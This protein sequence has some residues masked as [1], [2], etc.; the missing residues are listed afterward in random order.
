MASQNLQK[1]SAA[2]KTAQAT[3]WLKPM[4]TGLGLLLL[5]AG[6][7]LLRSGIGATHLETSQ[8]DFHT[9]GLNYSWNLYF[10][11][12]KAHR[13]FITGMVLL[14][15]A[16]GMIGLAWGLFDPTPPKAAMKRGLFYGIGAAL[17]AFIGFFILH[18]GMHQIGGYDQSNL[19][20]SSWRLFKGQTAYVD[21]PYTMPV[22][23]FLGGKFAFQ[24][25]GVYYRSFV[26]MIALFAIP[27]FA[28]SLFL[29]AQL[30]GRSWT[31]LLWAMA[32]QVFSQMMA[33]YWTY[34]PITAVAAVL[35][36]FSATYWLRRP[37]QK[38]ALASYGAALLL[39]A[40]MKPNVAGILIPG[41]SVIL[42]ISPN[43]R[44]KVLWV[45]LAAFALFLVFLAINHLSFSGM[46]AG[47]LSVAQRGASLEPF[48]ID[49]NPLEKRTAMV[50]LISILLPAVLALSQGRGTSRSLVS[51]IPAVAMLAG[52]WI[53][54]ANNENKPVGEATIFVPV[55]LALLLGFR[56]LRSLGPWIPTFALLGGLYGYITN[57]EQKLVDMPPVLCAALLLVGELRCSVF[58]AE[59]PVFQMPLWWN[60]YL[61]LACVVLVAA[62]L[63]QGV[64]RD[65]IQ[66]IGPVQFFEWDDS[67]HIIADGLF[68][69]VHCGDVLDEVVKE[70]TEVLRREPSSTV[71][72]G[73]R[74]Q[75]GYANFNVQS[76]LHEPV[77]W[78]GGRTMYAKS[79]EDYY[80]NNFL[81]SRRQLVILFKNDVTFLSQDE[82]QRM[83]QQYNVDQSFPVL[84][85]LHLK[86]G[87]P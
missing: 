27:T 82:V 30:F 21:F 6:L 10:T 42:F 55:A 51:W 1:P 29:L 72:F 83:A 58:P 2:S 19:V 22:A 54:A 74:M 78:D 75:W 4:G 5:L 66:S 76:P 52:F 35:Y 64:A 7:S 40:T 43:H 77:V 31:T 48:L 41:I 14:G 39:L 33:A 26:D 32:M 16:A 44:W 28:W 9:Q 61:A 57:S 8:V 18:Y 70:T 81:Q 69:G 87:L 25:F 11:G 15:G 62:G 23:Y 49:L 12:A 63:A 37:A 50:I 86:K 79:K 85:I 60:R 68:K 73:P 46:L 59:G 84:T 67:R 38:S 3:D 65:R 71:W 45:S 53:F 34:N 20:D 13:D 80:F 36:T 47:Y 24:W 17:A 56:N